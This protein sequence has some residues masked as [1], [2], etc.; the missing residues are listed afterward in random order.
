MGVAALEKPPLTAYRLVAADA[1]AK[2]NLT[3]EVLG[4]RSDGYH[5]IR[6][7]VIGVGLRDR[8]ECAASHPLGPTLDCSDPTL[9]GDDNLACRAAVALARYCACDAEVRIRLDKFIPV[10][11]GLGGGSSDAAATLRLCGE[12]W[13]AGMNDAQLA[14]V[15]AEVGS[16]VPLFFNLPSALISGRGERV[17]RASLRWSGWVLLVFPGVHV[18]TADVYRAWRAGDAREVGAAEASLREIQDVSLADELHGMLSN[19]LEPAVFRVCPRVTE[20]R[21]EL[22]SLGVSPI[23]VTGSGSALYRLF[24]DPEAARDAS[25]RIERHFP[26]MKTA[27]VAAPVGVGPI[28]YKE[29]I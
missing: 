23:R 15:G 22:Q 9:H 19:Q 1:P 24:D 10:G 4:K 11:A 7:L 16:D 14:A 3:L 27:V 2:I 21:D 25:D 17:E 12:L 6:S 13:R 26:R 29:K 28:E 8:I 20:A 18:A 5:D